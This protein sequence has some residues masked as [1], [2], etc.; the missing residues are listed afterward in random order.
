MDG[1]T[2]PTPK[3]IYKILISER[4]QYLLRD[5][6]L[7]WTFLSTSLWTFRIRSCSSRY[8]H[9]VPCM[10]KRV[11][12]LVGW[13]QYD[14]C[15]DYLPCVNEK[16]NLLLH[17]TPKKQS[18]SQMFLIATYLAVRAPVTYLFPWIYSSVDTVFPFVSE[19]RLCFRP[20]AV[21]CHRPPVE[22]WLET[23]KKDQKET[24]KKE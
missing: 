9:T 11:C 10:V 21:T 22:S 18:L 16:T 12:L 5:W 17:M 13:L 6:K 1:V 24:E 14:F 15:S 2:I 19:W 7:A 4:V 8:M 3:A 20:N 23:C